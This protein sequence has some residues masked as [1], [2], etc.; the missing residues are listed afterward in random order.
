MKTGENRPEARPAERM[1]RQTMTV[2]EY[3]KV[4]PRVALGFSG[5]TDSAFLLYAALQAG[6]DIRP[7]FVKTVF[8]P[9]FELHDAGRICEELGVTLTVLTPDILKEETVAANPPDRCYYC[10][11]II[12]TLLK[13]EAQ[14]DGYDWVVDGTNVSD[15]TADRPG[16]KALKELGVHSPLRECGL[17]KRDIRRCSKEAGL[18]TWDKPSYACLATRFSAGDELTEDKLKKV[19]QAEQILFE[20]GFTDVRVRVF[21]GAARLQ[22]PE[23]QLSLALKKREDIRK[24]FAPFFKEILLDMRGR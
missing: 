24:A 4:H 14:K 22:L 21:H 13:E 11:K 2:S 23:E 18:F 8:Q 3:F 7:Y 1:N 17:T 15:D 12:F 16:M 10:K 6:A 5:G 9:E 19:E 20:L